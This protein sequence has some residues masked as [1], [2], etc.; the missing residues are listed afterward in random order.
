MT[1]AKY[2]NRQLYA[3]TFKRAFFSSFGVALIC[4][5]VMILLIPVSTSIIPDY[6]IFNLD[7]THNQMKYRFFYESLRP[8]VNGMAVPSGITTALMLFRFMLVRRSSD[9]YFALGIKREKLLI[10]HSLAGIIQLFFVVVIPML[11]SM[12]MN[13]K[14]FGELGYTPEITAGFRYMSAGLF[15]LALVG[16][17]I[18]ALVCCMVGTMTEAGLFALIIAAGPSIILYGINALTKNLLF[19]NA[20]GTSTSTGTAQVS[21]SL[22]DK[23]DFLNPI[24]FFFSTSEHYNMQSERFDGYVLPGM[25]WSRI[26]GWLIV[27][28][29]IMVLAGL[30]LKKRKAEISGV[31]GKSRIF[32]FVIT[33]LLSF[34]GFSLTLSFAY[35]AGMK[36][37]VLAAVA[38]F[39]VIYVIAELLQVHSIRKALWK[40]PIQLGIT[41]IA[42]VILCTGGLGY[43]SSIPELKDIESAKIS[44]VGSPNYL[45]GQP[46]GMGDGAQYYISS[47]YTYTDTSDIET[48]MNLHKELIKAGKGKLALSSLNFSST[49]VPYDITVSYQLKNGSQITRY[50]DRTTYQ[51]LEDM[52]AMDD[53]DMVKAS[54]QQTI[55]NGDGLYYAAGAYKSGTIYLSNSWY[56]NPSKLSIDSSQRQ[57]LLSCIA[58]DVANQSVEERYFPK[59]DAVGIIMFSLSGDSDSLQFGY[60]FDNAVVYLTPEFTNTL[61]FFKDAGL[62]YCFD[63]EDEI[64]S[65]TL[66][67]FNPYVSKVNTMVRPS[68]A[69]FM[70]YTTGYSGEYIQ[71]KD[72]GGDLELTEPEEISE[73]SGLL[74][75]NYFMSGGGYLACVKIKGKEQYVYKFLP[76][77]D[78]P[79]D[80]KNKFQ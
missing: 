24:L 69:F 7:Y 12:I 68:S 47:T 39:L 34:L 50:Y 46:G 21:Q 19:G 66:Q 25:Q 6:S 32:R 57:E 65:I 31:S 18:T 74:Q 52:L 15:T 76:V 48:L 8:L 40:L 11:I 72:F 41:V 75:N 62:S 37:A 5:L 55:T 2:S 38:A 79:D 73:I 70:G 45:S 61:Q 77:Q 56:T 10:L 33:F 58:E 43:S 78:A 1:T 3:H 67:A 51:V 29:V 30:A 60:N 23:L 80:I 35:P 13:I 9:A 53:T 22:L 20:F 27:F 16:F 17:G 36:L 14:A 4:L 54:M 44:Y 42:T 71:V 59:E 64:E 28:V 49:F 26:I 63:F